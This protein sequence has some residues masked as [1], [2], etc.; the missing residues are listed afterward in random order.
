MRT[1][2]CE[3]HANAQ[4]FGGIESISF[5]IKEKKLLRNINKSYLFLS[6]KNIHKFSKI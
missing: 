5:K 2:I 6:E 4:L 1:S 3:I